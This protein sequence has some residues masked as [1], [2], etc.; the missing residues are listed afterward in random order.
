MFYVPD[1]FKEY[2]GKFKKSHIV[3]VGDIAVAHTDIIQDSALIGN[4]VFI[5]NPDKYERL[6]I[7]MDLVKVN[8]SNN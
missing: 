6:L 3:N 7:S 4:P 5:Q 2:A 8:L 1:R